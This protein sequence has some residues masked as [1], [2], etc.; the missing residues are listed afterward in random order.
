MTEKEARQAIV[1]KIGEY[2]ADW[3]QFLRELVKIE[4]PTRCEENIRRA[5]A[6][7]AGRIRLLWGVEP[8]LSDA[9]EFGCHV[10]ARAGSTA[11][12]ARKILVIGHFDTVQPIGMLE[13]MG[14]AEKD[15]RMYGPGIYD[16]KTGAASM[17]YA[18]AALKELDMLKNRQIVCLFNCDE[19]RGSARSKPFILSLA[20]ECDI[21]LIA[22]PSTPEGYALKSS[23][24]GICPH[25]LRVYGRASH[26]GSAPEKGV[27]AVVELARQILKI[28]EMND[29]ARGISLNCGVIR[30]GTVSNV[31]PDFAEVSIDVR[32]RTLADREEIHRRLLSLTAV[33]PGARVEVTGHFG[34]P[35]MENNEGTRAMLAKAREIWADFGFAEPLNASHSGG[36]S[37]GNYTSMYIPTLDGL[38]AV[39]DGGHSAEEWIDVE[40]SVQRMMLLAGLMAEA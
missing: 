3:Q 5:A 28:A 1:Q 11:P 34:R 13:T 2:R 29:Y 38:G 10:L 30:G 37:D 33:D 18:V 7:I 6:E 32:V 16:M 39:G 19:E 36:G 14:T 35:P 25:R 22:E 15:G 40:K 23:R 17:I 8:E 31:V 20:Q 24:S 9:G 21:A 12:D 27:S 4:T 26:A